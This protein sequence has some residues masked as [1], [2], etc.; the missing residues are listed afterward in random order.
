M[1]HP[2]L[3]LWI[4]CAGLALIAGCGGAAPAP[5]PP[6]GPPLPAPGIRS[7]AFEDRSFVGLWPGCGLAPCA[8]HLR[9][10]EADSLA[11]TM[12]N[13][14]FADLDGDGEDDAVVT[15]ETV[16]PGG[17]ST[18]VVYVFLW[19]EGARGVGRIDN[20]RLAADLETE[21]VQGVSPTS[22]GSPRLDGAEIVV[23]AV[24][25]RED[26]ELLGVEAVY[27]IREGALRLARRP[28]RRR[29]WPPPDVET[30]KA[31]TW[32]V[33]LRSIGPIEFGR[34]AE[35]VWDLLGA[36]LLAVTEP[37][38]TLSRL[39]GG[40]EHLLFRLREDRVDG[41]LVQV[42]SLVRTRSGVGV[43]SSR[44]AVVRAYG[45]RI[46]DAVLE[47]GHPALIYVPRDP[48]NAEYRL[49][50]GLDAEGDVAWVYA[51]LVPED[52]DDA[53]CW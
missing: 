2:T 1:R 12:G 14:E 44:E 49:V 33:L 9:D 45:D 27:G 50:F 32:P 17:A 21:S 5:Q 47:G 22:I 30:S 18:A 16:Q 6:A 31:T 13:V 28:I 20:E 35:R 34:S 46:E 24:D 11:V 19:D 8:I 41:A 4:F 38:C 39:D 48:S 23:G 3:P 10:G 53:V 42:D 29:L 15:L 25:S 36:D 40:P 26:G 52:L 43:R 37:P 7:V 51:G